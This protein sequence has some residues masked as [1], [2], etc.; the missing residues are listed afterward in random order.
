MPAGSVPVSAKEV[1][2]GDEAASDDV[3]G[4]IGVPITPLK[5]PTEVVRVG[6]VTNVPEGDVAEV[7]VPA[8][9]IATTSIEYSVPG[10]SP[11][12]VPETDAV[13]VATTGVPPPTGVAVIS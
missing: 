6:S 3:I 13:T 12:M 4:I 5:E 10:A 9:F 11:G 2:D 8:A 7:P 1:P